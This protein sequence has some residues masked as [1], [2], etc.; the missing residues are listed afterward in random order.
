MVFPSLGL[1]RHR[2]LEQTM[3]LHGFRHG[4]A[5]PLATHL[6]WVSPDRPSALE[7]RKIQSQGPTRYDFVAR[8]AWFKRD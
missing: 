5:G 8:N 7:N 6:I 3:L 1:G 4:G 2:G